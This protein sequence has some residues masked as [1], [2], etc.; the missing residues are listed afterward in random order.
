[1]ATELTPIEKVIRDFLL[2]EILYDKQFA[3]LGPRDLLL[4][5]VLDSISLTQT[6]AFCEEVFNISI[7]H[8]ELL[9]DHFENISAIAQLVERRLGSKQRSFGSR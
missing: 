5:G 2:K 4:D 7:P 9:P 1:M 6:V 3:D 8:E